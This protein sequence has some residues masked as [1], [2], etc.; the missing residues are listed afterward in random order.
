MVGVVCP[1]Q[2]GY[3]NNCSPVWELG[4]YHKLEE[5]IIGGGLEVSEDIVISCSLFLI[6]SS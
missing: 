5:Y 1:I 6:F 2:S 4:N 3:F